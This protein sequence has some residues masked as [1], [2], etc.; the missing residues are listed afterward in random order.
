MYLGVKLLKNNSSDIRLY[1]EMCQELLL[2]H[3]QNEVSVEKTLEN[4]NFCRIKHRNVMK[5]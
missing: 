1:I 2:K 5:I 3:W 4:C